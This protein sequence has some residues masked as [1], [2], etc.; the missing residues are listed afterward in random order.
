MTPVLPVAAERAGKD[1]QGAPGQG[2]GT[3]EGGGA[4]SWYYEVTTQRNPVEV[5][6]PQPPARSFLRD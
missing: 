3:G 1:S 2:L 4:A 6:S 5:R